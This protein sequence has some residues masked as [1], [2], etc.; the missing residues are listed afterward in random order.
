MRVRDEVEE[1]LLEAARIGLERRVA[2][3]VQPDA[4]VVGARREHDQRVGDERPEVD[5]RRASP[6]AAGG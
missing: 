2:L 4:R 6:P 1:R 5:A 3:R